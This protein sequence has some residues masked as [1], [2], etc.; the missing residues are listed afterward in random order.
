[1]K[2]NKIII[3][4]V[5]LII[6]T[7]S[8]AQYGGLYYPHPKSILS[9]A[10]T[11]KLNVNGF[12]MVGALLSASGT[13]P[14]FVIDQTDLNGSTTS[15]GCWSAQYYITDDPMNCGTGPNQL[16]HYGC[17]GVDII[18]TNPGTTGNP[19]YAI[20]GACT[21][22]IFFACLDGSGNYTTYSFFPIT[23]SSGAQHRPTI[24]ESAANP[25]VY[26]ICGDFGDRMF[27]IKINSVGTLSWSKTYS[28]P[29]I[30]ARAIIE[31]PSSTDIVVVGRVDELS[32]GLAAE[33][34]FM[35]LNSSGVISIFNCYSDGGN[36]DEWFTSIKHAV[37]T[38]G[39]SSGYI[40]GGRVYSSILS[41]VAY[42]PWMIKLSPSGSVIWSTLIQHSIASNPA[43]IFDVVERFN[44]VAT[45]NTYE[46]FGVAHTPLSSTS[47]YMTV[48]KL[49]NSGLATAS[50]NEFQYLLGPL[51]SATSYNPAQIGL[52]GTGSATGDGLQVFGTDQ[53]GANHIL[54]GA[55]FNGVTGGTCENASDWTWHQGPGIS[56]TPTFP[57]A[58]TFNRCTN[59]LF[60]YSSISTSP[61]T[62]CTWNSSVVGGSNARSATITGIQNYS[63]KANSIS[64]HPNPTNHSIT[65]DFKNE[66]N[67]PVLITVINSMGQIEKKIEISDSVT[68]GVVLDFEALQLN[69][70]LYFVNVNIN[71]ETYTNKVM[72]KK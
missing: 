39:G 68:N 6:V 20:A 58:G 49:N 29:P 12:V 13:D 27:I 24:C 26:Y 46:Y 56:A 65:L 62:N 8:Y 63:E 17:I 23:S 64:V 11:T 66:V 38:N 61:G 47:N 60:Y 48:W 30:W 54:A 35:K 9:S 33:A 51:S 43:E 59:S 4:I 28:G 70:G 31:A 57:T 21:D 42:K 53:N 14:D 32:L 5:C 25:G 18:E 40:I 44:S 15:S 41:N 16:R 2:N 55:Y 50:P 34:F 72:Y 19:K 37:S 1:M 45:P 7:R 36:G 71:K 3:A 22:G 10:K 52:I 67:G 69:E